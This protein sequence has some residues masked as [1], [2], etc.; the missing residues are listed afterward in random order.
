MTGAMTRTK[1][2]V[3]GDNCQD[4][5]KDGELVVGWS[6]VEE[7]GGQ[8]SQ[9]QDELK[10]AMVPQDTHNNTATW[11]TTTTTRKMRTGEDVKGLGEISRAMRDACEVC[12]IAPAGYYSD[13]DPLGQYRTILPTGDANDDDDN[14]DGENCDVSVPV[15][16]NVT[17]KTANDKDKIS[18]EKKVDS[19]KRKRRWG[20]KK[21]ER[22]FYKSRI[23]T[24]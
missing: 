9:E 3:E 2:N 10:E 4:E 5:Q 6:Q 1:L 24:K 19:P 23:Y 12:D 20:L 22:I 8:S 15:R 7:G 11:G 21:I 17:N 16:H 18:H 14:N 13:E